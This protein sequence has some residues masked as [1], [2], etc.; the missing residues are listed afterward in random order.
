MCESESVPV[1]KLLA[2]LPE[3]EYQR[4]VPHLEQVD[5]LCEQVLYEPDEPIEVVYFP[6]QGMVSLVSILEEGATSEIGVVGREGIVGFPAFLG[7][8]FTTSYAIVQLSGSAV[9]LDAD[10]LK[11]E[12]E[13]G[14][15][16]HRLLLLYT[17]ALLAQVSQT[18]ACNSQH[19][20]EQRLARWLLSASDCVE[21]DELEM[22][23]EFLGNMLGIRRSSVTVAAGLLQKMGAIQYRRGKINIVDRAALE[24]KSCECYLLVKNEYFRLL[25]FTRL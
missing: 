12:F 1:N 2:A 15:W 3:A 24:A 14:E 25:G 23:Q 22:T 19:G 4:L 17:Q 20:V 10:I 21:Q 6:T 13:R 11:R 5:L 18:A 9:M 7:G 16:L 8:N